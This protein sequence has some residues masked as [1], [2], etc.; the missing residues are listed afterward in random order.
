MKECV[1]LH[2]DEFVGA[3]FRCVDLPEFGTGGLMYSRDWPED[4]KREI[5]RLREEVIALR[6]LQRE[7]LKCS[8]QER[9]CSTR[10]A[11]NAS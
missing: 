1:D 8:H 11:R 9:K 5:R 6:N 4:A 2:G 10:E 3:K 7:G